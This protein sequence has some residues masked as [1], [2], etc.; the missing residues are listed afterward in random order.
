MVAGVIYGVS[1]G[2]SSL[3]AAVVPMTFSLFVATLVFA[4]FL[5]RSVPP[6]RRVQLFTFCFTAVAVAI[7]VL[8]GWG[9]YYGGWPELSD[10]GLI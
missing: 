7:V 8:I 10:V 6:L 1:L 2:L 5:H 9:I 3:E 4:V